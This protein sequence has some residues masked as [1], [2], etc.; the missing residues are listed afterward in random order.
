MSYP[1]RHPTSLIVANLLVTE[2][3][4]SLPA[5]NTNWPIFVSREPDSPDNLMAVFDTT[6]QQFG[7]TQN[8]GYGQEHPGVM[9]R[10]RSADYS[11][12]WV[13]ANG[14]KQELDIGVYQRTIQIDN[15]VYTIAAV[16]RRGDVNSLGTDGPN[17]KRRLFSLNATISF[18]NIQTL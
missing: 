18:S 7:F 11:T 13:K 16:T 12:G 5:S 8:D 4:A 14:V 9:I 1:T 6:G 10:F 3:F 2:G 15:I 17:G